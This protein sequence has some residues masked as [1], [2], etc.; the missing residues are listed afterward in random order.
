M[1]RYAVIIEYDGTPF[2]G[3][4]AQAV[5]RSVQ[6][7]LIEAIGRLTGEHVKLQGAGRTDSG[8]HASG[9]VA[10]FD[11]ER[12]W[13]AEK[14]RDGLNYHLRPDPIGIVAAREVGVGFDARFSA[15]GR[16][17]RYRIL[18]RKAPPILDLN[19]VWWV[20]RP[21]DASLMAE[22][23]RH[24]VGRHDFTTFRAAGCQAAS[25]VKS[26]DCLEIRRT[27]DEIT[28]VAGA[29]SF[30]HHQVR[31]IVG[32]LKHVGEGRWVADD[33]RAALEAKDRT[34][35][36]ALAPSRGLYLVGV[37]YPEVALKVAT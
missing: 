7:C 30:L 32:S 21:L 2:V 22:G 37:D 24:L 6:S 31:S 20:P 33:I 13:P 36:G 8:V 12:A 10:H 27:G 25:P 16:H 17:Y 3:W 15:I 14:I 9:Q 18:A 35:C 26:L 34:R 1:P 28:I 23:A 5:G 29:R 11:L 19:R 4:Q